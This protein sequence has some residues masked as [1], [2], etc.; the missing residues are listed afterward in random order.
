MRARNVLLGAP[1]HEVERSLK[2]LGADLRTARLRR[3]LAAEEVAQKIGTSRFA[4]AD[5]ERGKP[6]TS[7]AVYAALLWVYG[8]A[9]RLGDLADPG[10]DAEGAQ[11][12]LLR[13]P[14]RA[15]HRKSL[16]NDF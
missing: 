11:L 6:S 15:R 10:T 16:S 7:V 13:T 8:L 9:D 2:K 12:A 14:L 3:N 1:P 5:A 4:V